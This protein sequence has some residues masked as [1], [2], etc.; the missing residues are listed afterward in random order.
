MKGRLSTGHPFVFRDTLK[1]PED[2]RLMELAPW[3]SDSS[4]FPARP[5]ENL[6]KPRLLFLLR[7]RQKQVACSRR[8]RIP[9]PAV[10]LCA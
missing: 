2:C 9:L 1:R 6:R 8:R 10:P 4:N 5:M 7:R 3:R